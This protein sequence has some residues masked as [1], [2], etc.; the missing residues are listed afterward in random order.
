MATFTTV[1][2]TLMARVLALTS[3]L[4]YPP[5]EGHQLRSWHLLKAL[6][7]R[8]DVTL[9][10]F[11]RSDD[12]PDQAGPLRAILRGLETFP[13]PSE[14]SRVALSHALLKGT[15]TR[16][17][18]LAAKYA[19]NQFRLRLRELA[20]D[21]DLVHVDML[22]L[23]AHADCVPHDVP[24]AMNAH[25]V[26]HHLLEIRASMER[27]PLARA[28]LK[29][30]RTRLHDFERDACRRADALLAC[31]DD[32]A[33]ALRVLSPGG[34][35]QVVPNGVDLTTN[36]PST[37]P[38][39]RHRLVFVG[40]MGW[41]PNRDGVEWFL[42]SVFPRI[43]EKRP[44]TEFVLVGKSDGL[45][46][47]A[48]IAANVR[49]AGFVPDLRPV[50]HDAAVYVVPLRAGSGTR[51][52]VLEAMAL[53]KAIVTTTIG[54]EGICL[55]PD[56]EAL[57]ADDPQA[58]ADAVLALLA[59]PYRAGQMGAAARQCAD[60]NFSWDGI[61]DTLLDFYTGVLAVRAEPAGAVA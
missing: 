27:R 21:A 52:K 46:V 37:A 33:R 23:M 54:S 47:P 10:S 61:G 36:R 34:R 15:L 42:H 58:F 6:A 26:E 53:G 30:Q 8:H 16:A 40:Q 35:L 44:D 13:I 41:F 59:D 18:F 5:T 45:R 48:R 50:V 24:L 22:P 20:Q 51:L 56:H 25:N 19:S 39:S 2:A 4:P 49:L 17:P 43:L 60:E 7:S 31:S 29:R 28:F 1:E 55:R 32:D 38:P 14:H 3:R 12:A 11:L 9:M 57:F